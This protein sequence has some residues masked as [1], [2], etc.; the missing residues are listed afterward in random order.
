MADSPI[1]LPREATF[2]HTVQSSSFSGQESWLLSAFFFFKPFLMIHFHLFIQLLTPCLPCWNRTASPVVETAASPGHRTGIQQMLNVYSSNAYITPSTKSCLSCA[3]NPTCS[4]TC[5]FLFFKVQG[6][7]SG[8]Y[9]WV[10][11]LHGH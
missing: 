3:L 5:S 7:G 6:L 2:D 1:S 8:C 4:L 11:L 9:S 10:M